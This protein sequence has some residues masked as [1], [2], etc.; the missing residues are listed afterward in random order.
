MEARFGVDFGDVRIHA[1]GEAAAATA[2]EEAPAL[3]IGTD[4]A[5][6]A[7]EYSP[8]TSPGWRLLAHELAHVVQQARGR[9]RRDAPLPGPLAERDADQAARAAAGGKHASVALATGEG[10]ARA[11]KKELEPGKKAP[12]PS[13]DVYKA[14]NLELVKGTRPQQQHKTVTCVSPAIDSKGNR[15]HLISSTVP[16]NKS[17]LK[18]GEVLVPYEGGHAELQAQRFAAKHGY[19]ILKQHPSSPFCP[20]CAF[21]ARKKGIAPRNALVTPGHGKRSP[22]PLASLTDKDLANMVKRQ[23][24]PEEKSWRRREPFGKKPEQRPPQETPPPSPRDLA[25]PK[26]TP[27]PPK[28]PPDR[29]DKPP[30]PKGT[31]PPPKTPPVRVDKPPPPKSAPP[32]PQAAA[33][34]SPPAPAKPQGS[35]VLTLPPGEAQP[36]SRAKPRERGRLAAPVGPRQPLRVQPQM[37]REPI[38]NAALLAMGAVLSILEHFAD[39]TQ[40]TR[41]E[42]EWN[43]QW[44]AIQEAITETGRG[45]MVYFEYTRDKNSNVLVFERIHWQVGG[46]GEGPPGTLRGP[47]KT[48]QFS[49]QYIAPTKEQA[50]KTDVTALKHRLDQLWQRLKPLQ[51]AGEDYAREGW[52]KRAY[53]E[54]KQDRIDITPVYDARSHLV[55]ARIAIEQKRYGAATESMDLA[56][57]RINE[58]RENV[59][60]YRGD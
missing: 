35:P 18:P 52:L 47:G 10:I 50:A 8:D 25:S 51:R 49:S 30:P 45:V 19:K 28:T 31:P 11:G 37:P 53:Q 7:R 60:A 27:P 41:A 1:G 38:G 26:G 22:V 46:R 14:R 24:I 43:R 21:W 39:K 2:R 12:E 56:A 57:R 48:P 34:T 32:P 20:H 42:A 5:F 6:A 40:R 23:A 29:V 9:K 15:V 55:S 3:T 13:S 54:R 16:L 44:P 33:T 58:M 59:R 17:Q 36:P 4:V